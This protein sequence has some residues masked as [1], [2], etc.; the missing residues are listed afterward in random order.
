[1]STMALQPEDNEEDNQHDFS[2]Y[3]GILYRITPCQIMVVI[4]KS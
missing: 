1:M 4:A 2:R 3:C